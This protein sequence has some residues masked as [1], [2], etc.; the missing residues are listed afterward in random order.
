[1][2][3]WLQLLGRLDTPAVAD[4]PDAVTSPVAPVTPVAISPANPPSNRKDDLQCR[5]PTDRTAA[6]SIVDQVWDKKRDAIE[7]G[8]KDIEEIRDELSR[9]YQKEIGDPGS[10][11]DLLNMFKHAAK[12]VHDLLADVVPFAGKGDKLAKTIGELLEVTG[13]THFVLEQDDIYKDRPTHETAVLVITNVFLENAKDE[14]SKLNPIVRGLITIYDL[15]QNVVTVTKNYTALP[16]ARKSFRDQLDL[17]DKQIHQLE[18][19]L[20]ELER[21]HREEII[22]ELTE[23]YKNMNRQC[24]AGPAIRQELR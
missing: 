7:S 17:L 3:W 5:A 14:V 4:L 13:K 19:K 2:G 22:D 20:D 1:M 21:Q 24:Q 10:A 18:T 12:I 11:R 9:E 8:L 23:A 16:E 15:G 6:A